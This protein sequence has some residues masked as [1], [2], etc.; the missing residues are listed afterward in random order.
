MTIKNEII[1]KVDK[2]TNNV[3]AIV[4][5]WHLGEPTDIRQELMLLVADGVLEVYDDGRKVRFA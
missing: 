1:K 3:L 4:Q 5:D 2:G